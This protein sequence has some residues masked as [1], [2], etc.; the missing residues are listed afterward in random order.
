MVRL[1]LLGQIRGRSDT[2]MAEFSNSSIAL[3]PAG[4][5]VPLTETAVNSKPCIVHRQ[6]AGIV[7][8]RGLTNQNRALFRVSYGGNI[9][10][11][12]GGTVE[13]I[14]A[15]LAING[16]PLTSATATVTPAAVE[17]YFNIYVSA[18]VCVSKGC[19]LTVAMENTST[20]AV[21]FANS[22]LTVERI[23]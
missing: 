10:I 17:N 7:T 6:G 19:C 23:A 18:Q 20:Q 15:A 11:P 4:Q 5:N 3:V 12:T 14:T 21:N 16:E 13:A 1:P 2:S 9:A 8:L 22:N